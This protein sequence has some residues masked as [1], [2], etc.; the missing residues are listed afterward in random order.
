MGPLAIREVPYFGVSHRVQARTRTDRD[1]NWREA[2]KRSQSRAFSCPEKI[3]SGSHATADRVG[4]DFA[5]E[6]GLEHGEFVL[7]VTER[8]TAKSL[9][10]INLPS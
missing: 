4:L 3:L 1:K 5:I 8:K 2:K 6:A 7:G 9:S 10:I